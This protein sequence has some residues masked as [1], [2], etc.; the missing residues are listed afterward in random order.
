VTTVLVT[1]AGGYIGQRV[2]QKLAADGMAVRALVRRPVPWGDVGGGVGGGVGG[3]V[4]GSVAEVVGDLVVDPDLAARAADGVDAVIHLAGANEVAVGTDPG[5]VAATTLAAERVALSGVARV[6]YL[7]TVHVYGEALVAGAVVSESTPTVPMHPYAQARLACEEVFSSSGVPTMAFRLTNSVGAPA[8]T[9]VQ[10][11]SLVANELCREG[12]VSGSLTLRS[13]GVQW[14]DFIALS[15]VVG[16]LSALV[17][18]VGVG[19][20]SFVPGIYN[21]GSG[22]SVTVRGLATLVQDSFVAA[23]RARPELI[24][25][26]APADPP[27]PYTVDV[28]RLGQLGIVPKMSLRQAVDETVAFCLAHRANLA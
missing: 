9:D 13:S 12:A 28:T 4:G 19:V 22:Q 8:R 21:M 26:P 20:P 2:V 3:V 15:D 25:P 1:G 6:I 23:G 10:R 24:A 5:A 14:R 11:W 27:G 18:G 17:R 7:S 16:W